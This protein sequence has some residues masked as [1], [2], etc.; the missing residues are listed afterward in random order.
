[1][2]DIL[3]STLSSSTISMTSKE[4]ADLVGKR[5]DNVKR[6]IEAL[7]GQCVISQPQVEGGAKA[8]N[9]VVEKLYRFSG[10][11]GKRDSIVVVAQLSPEFTAKL[12]DR[13][14]ELEA[15][16]SGTPTLPPMTPSQIGKQCII[17]MTD[18]AKLF[19]IPESYA[20]QIAGSE[21]VRQTGMPWDRLLTQAAAMS[22][23]PDEDVM[24]EPTDLGRLFDL[25]GAAMNKKLAELGLQV[26]EA[27][28]WRP[29]EEGRALCERHAW[30][31]GNK[32]GYNLKWKAA[33]IE[34]LLS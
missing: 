27:G 20:L 7:V 18:V 19:G 12:V 23:V 25:S 13:W 28:E 3:A 5:H 33:E 31:R 24:L 30:V 34:K 4:I 11:V 1:M 32:D 9:G 8:A 14:R 10:D 26:K 16:S 15:G 6:T 29:T 21:A 22:N 2:H 17:D